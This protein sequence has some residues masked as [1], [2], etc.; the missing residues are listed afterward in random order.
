MSAKRRSLS[1]MTAAEAKAAYTAGKHS[2]SIVWPEDTNVTPEQQAPGP[3]HCPF[4]EGDPQRIEWL[5]GLEAALGGDTFDPATV[6][7]TIREEIKGADH[8]G[9]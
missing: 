5:K 3:H 8:V 4:A 9:S 6:L 2:V 7:K 1:R